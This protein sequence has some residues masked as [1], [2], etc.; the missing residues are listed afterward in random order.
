MPLFKMLKTGGRRVIISSVEHACRILFLFSFGQPEWGITE[1]SQALGLSKSRVHHLCKTLVQS[2]VLE[3]DVKSRKYRLGVR[4]LEM[5]GV[6]LSRLEAGDEGRL[7]LN[8]LVMAVNETVHL[9]VLYDAEVVF[10]HK[11]EPPKRT[12]RMGSR[13]GWRAPAYSTALGKVQLAYAPEEVLHRVIEKGLKPYTRRTIT[14][15]AHLRQEMQMIRERGYAIDDAETEDGLRCV[16]V[17]IRDFRNEVVGAISISGPE[18]RI[19]NS[20]LSYLIKRL[21]QTGRSFSGG[22]RGVSPLS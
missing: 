7:C 10:V 16:A 22:V 5:G 14:D 13:I 19:C 2:G 17:P 15:P 21:K 8:E 12:I 20:H 4:L 3:Q 9:G 11:R 6:V 1:M 18:G